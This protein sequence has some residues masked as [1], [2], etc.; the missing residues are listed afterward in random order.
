MKKKILA[1]TLSAGM[2]LIYSM[3]I[4]R[5]NRKIGGVK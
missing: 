3:V 4:Y 2:A 1:L 5:L